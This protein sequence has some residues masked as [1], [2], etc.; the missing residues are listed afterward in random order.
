MFSR[1]DQE[2]K[3]K[4]ESAHS[5]RLS[6]HILILIPTSTDNKR[7]HPLERRMETNC[8]NTSYNVILNQKRREI[9][10]LEQ[11]VQVTQHTVSEVEDCAGKTNL[12]FLL[13]LRPTE[14]QTVKSNRYRKRLSCS[15]GSEKEGVKD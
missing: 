14:K 1:G 10:F 5:H 6:L 8:N 3:G 15:S 9:F 7:Y 13:L 12:L 2:K 4:K 11:H